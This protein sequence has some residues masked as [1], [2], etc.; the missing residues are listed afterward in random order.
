MPAAII[1][2]PFIAAAATAIASS[3]VAQYSQTQSAQK[4]AKSAADTQ[5]RMAQASQDALVAKE[6]AAKNEFL[7]AQQTSASQAQG[8]V[9]AK[10][11]AISRSQSI[12]TSPLGLGGEADVARKILLGA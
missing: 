11:R 4:S 8:V 7:Q 10:R 3:S 2:H 6:T 1:A 12:Y 5:M 9:T